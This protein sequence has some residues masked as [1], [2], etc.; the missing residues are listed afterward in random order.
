M[1]LRR[2]SPFGIAHE[3]RFVFAAFAGVG[4]AADAVHGDGQ[5]LVRFLARSSRTTS[6]RWRSASRFRCAGSTSSIGTGSRLS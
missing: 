5:R 4:L 6:R 2:R 1:A 3:A